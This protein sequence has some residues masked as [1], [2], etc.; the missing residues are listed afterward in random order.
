MID[1][2]IPEDPLPQYCACGCAIEGPIRSSKTKSADLWRYRCT[3]CQFDVQV[4]IPHKMTDL[5]GARLAA[6]RATHTVIEYIKEWESARNGSRAV[7]PLYRLGNLV[8]MADQEL[9]I[10]GDTNPATVNQALRMITAILNG[11]ARK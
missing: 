9:R 7:N 10:S 11:M 6:N 5:Q 2:R 8:L 1:P 4:R 3:A